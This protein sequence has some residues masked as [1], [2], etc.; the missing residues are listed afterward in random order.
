MPKE[1]SEYFTHQVVESLFDY[2]K[3]DTAN[4]LSVRED[5]LVL[6]LKLWKKFNEVLIQ[7]DSV[8]SEP[9]PEKE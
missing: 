1:I 5:K 2:L 9:E 8:F 3:E 6:R 7:M 4:H